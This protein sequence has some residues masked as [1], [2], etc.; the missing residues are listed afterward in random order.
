MSHFGG[1]DQYKH[2]SLFSPRW[3]R[4]SVAVNGPHGRTVLC[5]ACKRPPTQNP[6]SGKGQKRVPGEKHKVSEST[7][8]HTI[9][10]PSGICGDIGGDSAVTSLQQTDFSLTSSL[11][12]HTHEKFYLSTAP[13]STEPPSL[14]LYVLWRITFFSSLW[15][16]RLLASFDAP[17]LALVKEGFLPL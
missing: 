14:D 5:A 4:T 1:R 10:K 17:H 3:R 12:S 15:M 11:P 6:V 16:C 7:V 2:F 9:S 8:H 13:C